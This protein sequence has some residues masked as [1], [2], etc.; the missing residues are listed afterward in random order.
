ML[1]IS[2]HLPHARQ[3]VL[4]YRET[5]QEIK[6]CRERFKS[7]FPRHRVVFG[8]DA[9]TGL[10]WKMVDLLVMRLSL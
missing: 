9:N 4:S 2:A 6:C 7:A 3:S 10:R 8:A 5:L 1:I